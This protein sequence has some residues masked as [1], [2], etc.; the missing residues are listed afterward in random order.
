MEV[1]QKVATDTAEELKKSAAALDREV[2][3]KQREHLNVYLNNNIIIIF[4]SPMPEFVIAIAGT[5]M[6]SSMHYTM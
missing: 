2:P 6:I 3:G 1:A 4:K 5:R